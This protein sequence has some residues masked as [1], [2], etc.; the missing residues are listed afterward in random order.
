MS[1]Y[2]LKNR[3]KYSKNFKF[4][5]KCTKFLAAPS[6]PRKT[7]FPNFLPPPLGRWK[8]PP[9]W[10][11]L[12]QGRK[13]GTFVGG[14]ALGFRN[15]WGDMPPSKIWWKSKNAKKIPKY[16]VLKG[17][18]ISRRLRR[19]EKNSL[20]PLFS[21]FIALLRNN[22]SKYHEKFSEPYISK[23]CFLFHF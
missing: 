19:R 2:R 8:S 16:L 5:K 20:I 6:G 11:G 3:K 21:F 1:W 18:K 4:Q 23:F 22:F 12:P 14:L 9:P 10:M 15:W 13:Y 7:F 17:S